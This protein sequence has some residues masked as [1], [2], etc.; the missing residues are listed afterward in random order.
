MA[1][2]KA[3]YQYD[4]GNSWDEIMF[5]TTADQ[6][7]ESSSKRFVSDSEKSKWNGKADGNHTHSYLPLSGG[8]LT[9]QLKIQASNAGLALNGNSTNYY[10]INHS[11]ANN[12]LVFTYN[13]T[14][15]LTMQ[16]NGSLIPVGNKKLN[17]GDNNNK[18]KS[19]YIS[20]IIND[21]A[22]IQA[23]TT[24]TLQ[25]VGTVD[26][27]TGAIKLGTGGCRL[28]GIGTEKKLYVEG[29]IYTNLTI[30][31]GNQIISNGA[32][33]PGKNAQG[34]WDLGV[35]DRR[36]YT[37]YAVNTNLS[38]DRSMKEDINYIDNEIEL[39]SSE[40]KNP[41]PFKDFICN[42]LKV[43]TYKYKRQITTENEDG[44]SE[45][46]DIEH[47]PQD[48]QI[49]FIA[50]DIRNTEVGS[51]FV[52]GE[53]GNMNYSPSGFT[54]VVAKALQEEIKSRDII[55]QNMQS[56]IDELKEKLNKLM[57]KL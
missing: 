50:Q 11:S 42:D 23:S 34:G 35:A 37:L 48:S 54:T 56:Q 44:T 27:T 18:F 47:E 31:G 9:G 2:K 7:V 43:A 57:T 45:V 25:V 16:N 20:E 40:S 28:Y 13:D 21:S 51:M 33:Y 10:K 41:T 22:K 19:I 1:T 14:S 17:L 5:K 4:N 32:V 49:G 52:Y 38:S 8:N 24:N 26:S 39:S 55:N 12:T 29:G 36:F 30:E 15:I 3:T 6:V 46:E 53:D